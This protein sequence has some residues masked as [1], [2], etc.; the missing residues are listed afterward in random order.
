MCV[1][2]SQFVNDQQERYI[3]TADDWEEANQAWGEVDAMDPVQMWLSNRLAELRD[4][5]EQLCSTG[6]PLCDLD[7]EIVSEIETKISVLKS[8][9]KI[10]V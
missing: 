10:L 4:Q 1:V 3:A 5:L 7:E 9:L 6:R 2:A 8:E